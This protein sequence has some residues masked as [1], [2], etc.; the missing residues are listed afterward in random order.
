MGASQSASLNFACHKNPH[1]WS[2]RF[3]S[4]YAKMGQGV[5]LQ[6]SCR[7]SKADNAATSKHILSK[8]GSDYICQAKQNEPRAN[9]HGSFFHHDLPHCAYTIPKTK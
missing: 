4:V 1:P 7:S 9:A 5:G 6:T 2:R 3:L 8:T